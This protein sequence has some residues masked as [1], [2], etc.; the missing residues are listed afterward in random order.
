MFGNPIQP[1]VTEEK[2]RRQLG[3]FVRSNQK[4]I[5]ALAWGLHLEN[6][7]TTET[8]G[9]DLKP[10]PHF[11]YCPRTAI[12]QLNINANNHFR[13]VLGIV[14]NHNPEKEVLIIG[15]G[16][17]QIKLIQYQ[18]QPTPPECFEQLGVDVD[19]LV[20][21]LEQQMSEQIQAII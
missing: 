5:A 7:Q 18:P 4:E 2:W 12:E 13:E 16:A 1:N 10:Q 19:T 15:I 11:V 21:R 20:S 14:E 17:G 6:G 9:I 3:E 8:L